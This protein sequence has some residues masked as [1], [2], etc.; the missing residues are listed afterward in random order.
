[1]W[2]VKMTVL[3]MHGMELIYL[4]QYI[5][6]YYSFTMGFICELF[7][8]LYTSRNMVNTYITFGVLKW[9]NRIWKSNVK[10]N[11]Y[12]ITHFYQKKALVVHCIYII[13]IILHLF[14]RFPYEND[15]CVW[16]NPNLNVWGIKVD[17][18]TWT[19]KWILRA[20]Q[21]DHYYREVWWEEKPF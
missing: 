6:I 16:T 21:R 5:T 19:S 13:I 12:R 8:V 7:L 17:Q 14:E 4:H 1:M 18:L 2:W 15:S 10:A 3:F 20:S 9:T 11:M